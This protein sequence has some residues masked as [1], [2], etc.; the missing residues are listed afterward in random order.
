MTW[1]AVK[2]LATK[3]AKNN[4]CESSLCRMSS[5]W[6]QFEGQKVQADSGEVYLERPG[7]GA[8]GAQFQGSQSWVGIWGAAQVTDATLVLLMTH[9]LARDGWVCFWDPFSMFVV[10]SVFPEKSV[11]WMSPPRFHWEALSGSWSRAEKLENCSLFSPGLCL[12]L[13]RSSGCYHIVPL[14]WLW[15]WP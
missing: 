1:L 3:I 6:A 2:K 15:V 4:R 13:P 5:L 11:L 10:L 12:W 7:P 9:F 8:L 14:L